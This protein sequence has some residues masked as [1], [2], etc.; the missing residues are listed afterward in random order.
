MPFEGDTPFT[1]GVKHKS[2]I[3]K[4]PKELNAQIPDDLSKLI[5]RCLEKDKAKRYQTAEE[6]ITELTRIEK[7]IP[8]TERAVPKSKPFTSRQIT[9]TFG[10]KKLLIP[11]LGIIVVVLVALVIWRFLPKH[12]VAPSSLRQA[13]P[14]HPLF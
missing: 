8:T 5:L 14:R 10:A 13:D 7:G 2:E 11:A 1:I 6:L 12:H 4:N 3:P 9:V